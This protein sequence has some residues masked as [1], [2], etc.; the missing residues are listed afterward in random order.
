MEGGF[1]VDH[2]EDA[3]RHGEYDGGEFEGGCFEAEEEGE[4][5]DEDEDGGFAHCVEG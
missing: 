2:Q 5:E 1:A 4:R 3:Q